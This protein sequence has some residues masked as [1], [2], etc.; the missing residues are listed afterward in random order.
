[1]TKRTQV[2]EGKLKTIILLV[3][4]VSVFYSGFKL[5]PPYLD[6]YTLKEFLVSEVRIALAQRKPLDAVRASIEKKI[7]ELEIP[8]KK[9][10]IHIRDT[11]NGMEVTVTYSVTVDLAGYP[12][13]LDFNPGSAEKRV[14]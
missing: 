6:D 4:V 3:V 1:M 10:D 14:L 5:I 12:I 11:G 13:K 2:G 7:K 8:A 9:E